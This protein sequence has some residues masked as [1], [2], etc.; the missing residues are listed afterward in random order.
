M[1]NRYQDRHQYFNEL[2]ETSTA[3]Y[4]DY[5]RQFIPIA[6][7]T[8]VLEVGC[9]EGGNLLPF[10][11]NGC[12]VVGVDLSET[13][14]ENARNYFQENRAEGR[15]FCAD[16]FDFP[17]QDKPFDVILVHDVIEHIPPEAKGRFLERI[18][19]FLAPKAVAF[20][21]FPAWQMP[22]GGHQQTCLRNKVRVLPWIHLLPMPVYRGILRL[23]REPDQHIE[24]LM[25]IRRSRMTVEKF[26]NL[27]RMAGYVVLER[28]LWLVNPHYKAKFGLRPVRLR[29]GLD[30]IPYLRNWLSTSCWFVIH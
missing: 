7:G 1:G 19:A 14:I 26:E 4:V 12:D 10:A 30:R 25:D 18:H 11:L 24:E 20:L 29:L 22:F 28:T 9:G 15:F 13:K 23:F 16:F 27:C 21:A 2:V 17:E 6:E 8:R 5:I 3:F